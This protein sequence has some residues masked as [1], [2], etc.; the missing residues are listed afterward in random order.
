MFVGLAQ[1][2]GFALCR[3]EVRIAPEASV[4]YLES[5]EKLGLTYLYA[6]PGGEIKLNSYVARAC[7]EVKYAWFRASLIGDA[8]ESVTIDENGKPGGIFDWKLV[9]T[10]PT[11]HDTLPVECRPCDATTDAKLL[12]LLPTLIYVL[13]IEDECTGCFAISNPILVGILPCA[14][15]KIDTTRFTDAKTKDN[16]SHDDETATFA[17]TVTN[18]G[19][20]ATAPCS[21]LVQD[22]LPSGLKLLN[23]SADPKDWKARIINCSNDQCIQAL[24][25][26]ALPAPETPKAAGTDDSN[27]TSPIL[28]T[29]KCCKDSRTNTAVVFSINP[30]QFDFNLGNNASSLKVKCEKHK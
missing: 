2:V 23:V 15:L 29:V 24:Y 13:V 4:T 19:P 28:V 30:D 20:C 8:P 5:Q 10:E 16:V 17:I 21:V 1:A 12:N 26:P 22:C 3:L 7:R 27:T 14:D 11:L 25:Q 9:G 18:N 6:C